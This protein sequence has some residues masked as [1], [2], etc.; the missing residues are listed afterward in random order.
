MAARTALSARGRV[1]ALAAGITVVVLIAFLPAIHNDFVNWDDPGMVV[2]N[3]GYRGL[4]PVQVRWAFTAVRFSHYHPLTWLSYGVDWTLWGL[5]P[6]GYHLTN[7]LLHALGAG[8]VF[9]LGR[10]LLMLARPDAGVAVELGAAV[11][12]LVFALHPLRVEPVAWV[13]ARR[14]VL[15][16][17]FFLLT[18][19]AYVR[20]VAGPAGTSAAARAEAVPG[21]RWGLVVAVVLYAAALLSKSITMTL[22]AVLVILDWYPL[23]RLADRRVWLEKLP[24]AVLALAAAVEA[25]RAVRVEE[26]FTGLDVYGPLDRA[27]LAAYSLMFYLWKTVVPSGLSAVY[28]APPHIDIRQSPFLTSVMLVAA[29]TALA[30]WLRRRQPGV[31]AA[32]AG[33][34]ATLLPVSGLTHA[35]YQLAYDRYSYI[36]GVAL[37]LLAGGGA[38]RLAAASRAGRIRRPLIIAMCCAGVLVLGAW[39][40]LSRR[41][42]VVWQDSENLWRAALAVDPACAV[43]HNGLG[44]VFLAVRRFD[45]AEREF[46]QAIALNPRHGLAVANLSGVL[47]TKGALQAWAGRYDDAIALYTEAERLFPLDPEPLRLLERARAAAR[48]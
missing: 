18:L 31:T 38:A 27:A 40:H 10:R 29:I 9:L 42:I 1:W 22:P 13:T 6:R 15:S 19:L 21:R 20:A 41:Q 43:C 12:A 32:W 24:F 4:G 28:E 34:V 17:A 11:A 44:L 37:G 26:N 39:T 14:D 47:R 36:P 16:S 3:D 35:G 30:G 46:R 8:C 2:F 23:R 45:D 25:V 5:D 7:V 48:R 33:Y